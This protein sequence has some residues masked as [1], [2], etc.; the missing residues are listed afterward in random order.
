MRPMTCDRAQVRT[1]STCPPL[2]QSNFNHSS[3]IQSSATDYFVNSFPLHHPLPCEMTPISMFATANA[4]YQI[5]NV[6]LET[7]P[8]NYI[9]YFIAL[10]LPKLFRTYS[11]T[12]TQRPHGT[13]QQ[14][15]QHG[16]ASTRR[17]T[18]TTTTG[19]GT[20]DDDTTK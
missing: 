1:R 19:T 10:L 6:L 20:G 11:M 4:T 12:T 9:S 7:H 14:Q 15:R 3:V 2:T 17:G 18:T 5:L 16:M 8:S 13:T